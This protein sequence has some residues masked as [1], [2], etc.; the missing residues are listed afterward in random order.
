MFINVFKTQEDMLSLRVDSWPVWNSSMTKKI[1]T[2]SPFSRFFPVLLVANCG[3]HQLMEFA[4][5]S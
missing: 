5:L 3:L 1:L 2:Q 4:Q